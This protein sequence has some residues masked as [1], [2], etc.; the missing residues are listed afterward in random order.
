MVVAKGTPKSIVPPDVATFASELIS[1]KEAGE[2]FAERDA[3]EGGLPLPRF[4]SPDALT[5]SLDAALDAF[6]AHCGPEHPRRN[7]TI[8]TILEAL[9]NGYDNPKESFA[10]IAEAARAVRKRNPRV[11]AV[12]W[13][14][15]VHTIKWPPR[16][17]S[18]PEEAQGLVRWVARERE[19]S[20]SSD[21]R[22]AEFVV[23]AMSR[24]ENCPHSFGK[25]T[26]TATETFARI[27]AGVQR[28][29]RLKL[30]SSREN[31]VILARAL[32][33]GWGLAPKRVDNMFKSA[34]AS[35]SE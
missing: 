12:R 15:Q 24:I 31:P 19:R 17:R 22:A 4:K 25:R 1:Q 8:A 27:Y 7:L 32:L 9:V 2:F 16:V 28:V 14:E 6:L 10:G 13:N 34:K 3:A 20:E 23:E 21:K 35:D 26:G 11:T 29:R 33:L 5:A 30:R 18:Q